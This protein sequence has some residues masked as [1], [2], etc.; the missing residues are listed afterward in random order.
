MRFDKLT[1]KAQEAVTAAQERASAN[2]H[3]VVT[4]MH[5]LAAM[6][7]ESE[8]GIVKP[9][10]EKVGAHLPRLQQIA[11]GELERLPKVS[12]G[13]MT[14]DRKLEEVFS[15]AQKETD[16]LK[17]EYISTEHLLLALLDVESEAKDVLTVCGAK[18]EELLAALKEIRGGQRVSTQTPEDTYQALHRYGRDLVELARLGKIDPVIGRDDEIRRCMQV[19]ARRRKNNPVLIG[20]PGVGKTAIVE[21]MALR[22]VNGDVPDALKNRHIV[23]LDMGALIA[24][25]KY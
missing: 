13:Q 1:I 23:A 22:I 6:V 2:Q 9:I 25:A 4:P 20:E 15:A 17:D 24:G 7:H 14:I 19:L 8:G 12:G 16:K 5:L 18:H 11:D 3:A 10:L 21:G